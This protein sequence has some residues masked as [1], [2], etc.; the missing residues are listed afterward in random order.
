MAY[1]G[2]V[3]GCTV[4]FEMK[5]DGKVPVVFTL[6]GRQITQEKIYYERYPRDVPLYP[7]IGMGKKGIQ[8]LARVSELVQHA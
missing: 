8:V 2:D 6:N 7:Y 3:I 1:R 5:E 4:M